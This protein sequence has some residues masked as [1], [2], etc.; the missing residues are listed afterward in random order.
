M[1][2]HLAHLIVSGADAGRVVL[3]L[4][5]AGALLDY[6]TEQPHATVIVDGNPVEIRHL[7]I[8]VLDPNLIDYLS[9][10][11]EPARTHLASWAEG[12]LDG[13]DLARLL[14]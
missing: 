14:R 9:D 10:V 12:L 8:H 5:E 7:P 11:D 2:A 3:T 13:D 4:H 6:L 1:N